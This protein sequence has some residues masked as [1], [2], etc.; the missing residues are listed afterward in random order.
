[1]RLKFFHVPAIDSRQAEEELNRFLA[2]HKV[3]TVD[4]ELVGRDSGAF[5]AICVTYLDGSGPQLGGRKPKIDYK[6]VLSPDDFERFASLRRLRKEL[7][8]RDG[9]PPYALFTNEQLATMV[10]DKVDSA[11]ELGKIRGVG[12]SRVKKYG[13]AFLE[14]LKTFWSNDTEAGDAS[15]ND[16]PAD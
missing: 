14:R 6:E 1:M 15:P 16:D 5:W 9:V 7:A 12:P 11:T 2:G 8:E 4:H 13:P 10:R 3:A